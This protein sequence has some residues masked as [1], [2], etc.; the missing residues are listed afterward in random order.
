MTKAA[1][2]EGVKT[3]AK[4]AAQEG[5]KAIITTEMRLTMAEAGAVMGGL[6]RNRVRNH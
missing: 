5:T 6:M 3:I 4:T 1:A 2:K